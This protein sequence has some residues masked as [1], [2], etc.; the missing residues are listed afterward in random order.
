[1]AGVDS[2]SS[3]GTQRPTD[4]Y[5]AGSANA[6]APAASP[7]PAGM[8]SAG[9]DK[10]QAKAHPT[11]LDPDFVLPNEVDFAPWVPQGLVHKAETREKKGYTSLAKR[12]NLGAF[13]N[14]VGWRPTGL[15]LGQAL[16]FIERFPSA[17]RIGAM[18]KVAMTCFKGQG[19]CVPGREVAMP[20]TIHTHRPQ[21]DPEEGHHSILQSSRWEG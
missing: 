5:A 2:V 13:S 19:T 20:V 11:S 18:S 4:I 10:P 12:L 15:N 6:K 21:Y 3:A 14:T 16:L 7:W 8:D 1:M 9:P 17:F